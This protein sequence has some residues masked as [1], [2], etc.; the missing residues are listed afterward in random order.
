MEIIK[1]IATVMGITM[2]LGYYPQLWKIIRSKNSENISIVS[3]IIFSIGT[4]TWLMYGFSIMDSVIIASFSL[5]VTGA[6]LILYFSILYRHK[7][8]TVNA[9]E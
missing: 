1:I 2:S 4:T 3:Y 5:G 9:H 7:K 6:V 8:T